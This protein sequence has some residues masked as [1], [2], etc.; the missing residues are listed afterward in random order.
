MPLEEIK[1]PEKFLASP[2][3]SPTRRGGKQ[4]RATLERESDVKGEQRSQRIGKQ[5]LRFATLFPGNST[6]PMNSLLFCA[7]RERKG[8][9]DE[10]WGCDSRATKE[11]Q[12]GGREERKGGLTEAEERISVELA[13]RIA[14]I[15][16]TDTGGGGSA[17]PC[18]LNGLMIFFLLPFTLI[19]FFFLFLE[20]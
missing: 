9:K 15:S 18:P 20:E 1:R 2:P 12:K 7:I 16:R 4:Y 5:G 11:W 10:G 17:S 8:G 14:R 6:C 19:E 13:C 3:F